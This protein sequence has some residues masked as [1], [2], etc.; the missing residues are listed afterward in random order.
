M[1]YGNGWND[2]GELRNKAPCF[3]QHTLHKR[4]ERLHS[5]EV[6]RLSR[7]DVF[8]PPFALAFLDLAL[9]LPLLRTGQ[10]SVG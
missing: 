7:Y 1:L 5:G 9:D 10:G 8:H 4:L 3:L 6:C 2:I